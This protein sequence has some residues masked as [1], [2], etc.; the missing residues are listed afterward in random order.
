MIDLLRQLLDHPLDAAVGRAIVV[1]NSAVFVG[2]AVLFLLGLLVPTTGRE[3]PTPIGSTTP[4]ASVR[5]LVRDRIAPTPGTAQDP[6]D[7]PRSDAAHRLRRH[8][9]SRRALQ[10]V[11][12][13]SGDVEIDL[14]GAIHGRALL[15]VVAPTTAAAR[16]GWREFLDRFRDSGT[17]Y[18]PIFDGQLKFS[19]LENWGTR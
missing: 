19:A 17:S 12:Y 8:L 10:H 11:P 4:D 18:K 15:R 7:A 1:L 13:R 6:Q 3:A 5:P 16:Q 2:V 14:V 9:A